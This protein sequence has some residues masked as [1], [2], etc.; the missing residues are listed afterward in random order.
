[1]SRAFLSRSFV[2]TFGAAPHQYLSHL[3]LEHAKRVLAGGASVT[4]ACFEVGFESV[5]TFSSMFHRRVGISPRAWQRHT[6]AVVQGLGL[7]ALWIPGCFL[8]KYVQEYSP[9]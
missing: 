1:M 5:G 2:T 6:R 7:P 9:P 3:R 8:L 4:D